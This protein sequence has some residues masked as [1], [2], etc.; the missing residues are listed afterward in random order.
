MQ[1]T[2]SLVNKIVQN[3]IVVLTNAAQLCTDIVL[4]SVG[5]DISSG[6]N[7]SSLTKIGIGNLFYSNFM[8]QHS[9]TVRM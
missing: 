1:S 7:G 4:K 2:N 3:N 9:K 5:E 8:A 6:F